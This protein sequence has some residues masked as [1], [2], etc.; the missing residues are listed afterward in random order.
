MATC[1]C[2]RHSLLLLG[3][4][5]LAA[6]VVWACFLRLNLSASLPSGLYFLIPITLSRPLERGDL[7]VACPPASVASFG[8]ARGFLGFGLC[9]GG[10]PELLKPVGALPGDRVAVRGGFLVVNGCPVAGA[11]V[12]PEDSRGRPLSPFS[13]S[14]LEVPADSVFLLSTHSPR[15]WDSRYFGPVPL[16]SVRARA[17][18]LWK[19][20]R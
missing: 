7:V 20:G 5:S 11:L 10:V 19:F 17:I 9:P 14:D 16:G 8:R 13:N 2:P 18:P 15:S 4:A 12:L 3:L 6:A 1:R